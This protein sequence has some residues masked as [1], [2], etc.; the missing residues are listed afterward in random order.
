MKSRPKKGVFYIFIDHAI[1]ICVERDSG[2]ICWMIYK[3]FSYAKLCVSIPQL[4]WQFMHTILDTAGS[5]FSC[6]LVFYMEVVSLVLN[7]DNPVTGSPF[8]SHF[9]CCMILNYTLSPIL[10]LGGLQFVVFCECLNLF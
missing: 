1:L 6:S 10:K 5:S 8:K 4:N 3:L 9:P 7:T 2:E